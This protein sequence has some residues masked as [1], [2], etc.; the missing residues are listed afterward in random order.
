MSNTATKQNT[1]IDTDSMGEIEVPSDRYWGAQTQ[2]ALEHFCIGSDLMPRELIYSYALLKKAAAAV[3]HLQKRLS[4][5]KAQLIMRVCDEITKG[6]HHAEFPLHVWMTGSGTQFNM[7]IN[8]VIANRALELMGYEKGRYDI[9]HPL[10]HVNMSQSTNDV[11]PTALR[12]TLSEKLDGLM[13]EMLKFS[14]ARNV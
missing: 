9:L 8:E 10:N 5:E 4:K 2:R 12:M 13:K 1:R 14:V 6:K 3:N 7:N 11:Y